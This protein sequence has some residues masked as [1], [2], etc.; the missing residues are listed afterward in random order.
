L[1]NL[2]KVNKNNLSKKKN[3]KLNKNSIKNF[4]KGSNLKKSGTKKINNNNNYLVNKKEKNTATFRDP[5]K[6]SKNKSAVK[7]NKEKFSLNSEVEKTS[8]LNVFER[9]D[10]NLNERSTVLSRLSVASSDSIL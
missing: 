3:N 7:K 8:K 6:I 9:L 4:N 2:S 1:I 5:I 10:K